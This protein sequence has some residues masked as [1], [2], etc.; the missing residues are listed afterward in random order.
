MLSANVHIVF[1]NQ[2]KHN[3]R[4]KGDYTTLFVGYN[5]NGNRNAF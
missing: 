3:N 5:D 4:Q 1:N 2:A